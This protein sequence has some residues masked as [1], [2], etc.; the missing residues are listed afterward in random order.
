VKKISDN[1]SEAAQT[2]VRYGTTST[3]QYKLYVRSFK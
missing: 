3:L 2:T 1:I